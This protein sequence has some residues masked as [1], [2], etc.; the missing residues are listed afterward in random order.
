MWPPSYTAEEAPNVPSVTVT[1]EEPSAAI[2]PPWS[3]ELPAEGQFSWGPS[4]DEM[5]RGES[6]HRPAGWQA[7]PGQILVYGSEGAL[8][9]YHYANHLI[10]WTARGVEQIRLEDRPMPAQ[11]AAE[12]ASFV[13]SIREDT[14]PEV[15]GDDGRR[16]LAAV[17]GA[18][19]SMETGCRQGLG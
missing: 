17:L 3:A 1:V 10:L 19:R 12:L 9:I 15:T 11:F 8:R 2:E 6:D 7:N 5:A 16:A 4:W 13:T 18:Y 14:P